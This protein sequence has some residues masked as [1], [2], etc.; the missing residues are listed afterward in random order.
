MKKIIHLL[1]AIILST[2]LFGQNIIDKHFESYKAQDNF[3]AVNVSA[4]MFELAGYIE[5]DENDEELSELK[6]FIGTVKAFNLIAGREVTNPLTKYTSAI[7]KVTAS[8]EELMNVQDKD[9]RFTF[10]IDESNGIVHELVMVGT[11]DQELFI[12]SITGEMNL[13][14]LSKMANKIQS[15]GFSHMKM[16]EDHGAADL[17]IYPNPAVAGGTLTVELPSHLIGGNATLFNIKGKAINNFKITNDKQDLNTYD[18]KDGNYIL[19]LEN[20]GVSMKKRI[21]IQSK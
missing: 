7:A 2:P 15:S 6:D 21:I 4:K 17:K 1:I 11:T 3:T 16:L 20:N 9:D 8:H 12:A 14:D 18:L 13:R 19:E 10:F 5:F